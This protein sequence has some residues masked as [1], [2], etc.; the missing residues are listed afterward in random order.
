MAVASAEVGSECRVS[1]SGLGSC[2][3]TSATDPPS[4]VSTIEC[5]VMP[6]RSPQVPYSSTVVVTRVSIPNGVNGAF[7]LA[8]NYFLP[9]Y[10]LCPGSDRDS[11]ASQRY[12]TQRPAKD[13]PFGSFAT[14]FEMT[15]P[16]NT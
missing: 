2:L 15:S 4:D 6:A 10:C 8:E 3:L 14:H 5:S 1:V 11:A 9:G 13:Q 16:A 12:A 7:E